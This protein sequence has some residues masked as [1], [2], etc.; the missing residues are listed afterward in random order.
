MTSD[1]G[2]FA[3]AG[4]PLPAVLRGPLQTGGQWDRT[5]WHPQASPFA[6]GHA[7]SCSDPVS[8][9]SGLPHRPTPSRQKVFIPLYQRKC[10]RFFKKHFN[11][12]SNSLENTFSFGGGRQHPPSWSLTVGSHTYD[13]TGGG[14]GEKA[15][16][17]QA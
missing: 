9:E 11:S 3:L 10:K 8:L 2:Y 15:E 7:L 1:M 13:I 5:Q 12:F 4:H 14:G 17:S 6:W 16:W